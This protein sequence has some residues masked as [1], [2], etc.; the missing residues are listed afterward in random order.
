MIDL[1][2]HIL[3]NIDDGSRSLENTVKLA[4]HTVEQGVTHM[5]CTPH[6]HL[7]RYDN[8]ENDVQAVFDETVNAIQQ[9]NIPL[10]LAL[11]AEIRMCTDIIQW[12]KGNTLPIIGHWQ[13]KPAFLLEMSH[14]HI[15]VGI[16]NL[17]M[18]LNQNNV[19]AIIVHPERNRDII[20]KPER[21][22][23]LQQAGAIFQGTA[24]AIT[25]MFK[26]DVQKVAMQFLEDDVFAYVASDMH[27]LAKRDNQMGACRDL[28]AREFG[29]SKAHELSLG[30]PG[31]LT[32]SIVW[33]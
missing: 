8:H 10:K 20:A 13:G 5:M 15:P 29:D 6:W 4:A 24:G 3:P 14:S 11:A 18:W 1:H 19:Q 26:A 21:I 12:V 25:G 31:E 32:E 27:D 17:L 30:V 7:G 33:I 9:H 22:N 28:I 2:S 23:K 16:T